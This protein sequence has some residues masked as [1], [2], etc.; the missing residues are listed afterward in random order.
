MKLPPTFPVVE[1]VGPVQLQC[2]DS[3]HLKYVIVIA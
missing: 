3:L 2:H 1:V